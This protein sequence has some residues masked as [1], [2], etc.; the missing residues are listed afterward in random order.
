[1]YD[2]QKIDVT[3]LVDTSIAPAA[4]IAASRYYPGGQ[5]IMIQQLWATITVVT[6]AAIV[7]IAFKYRPTPGS[8]TGA[9]AVGSLKVPIGTAPGKTVFKN[10][11]PVKMVPGGEL[12][13]TTTGAGTGSA[14]VGFSGAPS[15]DTPS[16]NP[17]A[18]ASA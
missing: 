3:M 9:I 4:N 12:V 13:L 5:P 2:Q 7:D 8:D 11:A 17:N 16:N 6:A 1:M 10:V 14:T 18:I 15:W